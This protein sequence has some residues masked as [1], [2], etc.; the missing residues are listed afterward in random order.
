MS[1]QAQSPLSTLSCFDKAP[2]RSRVRRPLRFQTLQQN[3]PRQPGAEEAKH[4][5]CTKYLHDIRILGYHHGRTKQFTAGSGSHTITS[6][7][8]HA[9]AAGHRHSLNTRHVLTAPHLQLLVID[10]L[11]GRHRGADMFERSCPSIQSACLR[12]DDVTS[13]QSSG[14][15]NHIKKIKVAEA[16][17]NR[18][19]R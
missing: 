15:K 7:P 12:L 17:L 13:V 18:C 11:F 3:A 1:I 8:N 2:I 19:C 16:C 6:C 5:L 9:L 10:R 14:K 4:H